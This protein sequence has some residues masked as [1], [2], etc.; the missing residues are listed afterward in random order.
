MSDQYTKPAKP[1]WK[2]PLLITTHQQTFGHACQ[3]AMYYVMMLCIE[4]DDVH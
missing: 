2:I 1:H 4:K 3:W